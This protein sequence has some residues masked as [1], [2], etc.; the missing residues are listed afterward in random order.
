MAKKLSKS[1]L[2]ANGIISENAVLVLMIGLCPAL[3]CSGTIKDGFGMGIAS[4]FVLVCSN[5]VVSV[6]RKIIPEQIR[7]PMF[8]IVI[9]TFVTM[10]DYLMQAYFE[11]LSAVLGIFVPLI[12]VNCM[13]LGRAEAFAYRNGILDSIVDGIGMGAGFTLALALTGAVRELLGAGTLLKG[14]AL[15][16]AV[17]GSGFEPMIMMILPP[18]AFLTLGFL[19][20][21]VN[22]LKARRELS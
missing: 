4:M 18:G 17:F 9:S 16:V 12:V 15:E 6:I 19:I 11:S 1:T 14:T 8:I 7:I 20:A 13:I 2:F 3:A 10:T 5:V 22:W 21:I